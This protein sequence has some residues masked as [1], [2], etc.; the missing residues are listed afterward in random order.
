MVPF[1][2]ATG[3]SG[4][5]PCF[6][7]T[8]RVHLESESVGGKADPGKEVAGIEAKWGCAG[9]L[10]VPDSIREEMGNPNIGMG[11][12]QQEGHRLESRVGG[13]SK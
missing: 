8:Y 13:P 1:S 6:G 9:R 10:R 12:G 2:Y 4:C 3:S 7:R 11:I 5:D